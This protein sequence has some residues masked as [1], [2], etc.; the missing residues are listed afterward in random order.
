[1]ESMAIAGQ[2]SEQF[3]QSMQAL[4]SITMCSSPMEMAPT[5][6][7]LS[8]MPQH[9]QESLITQAIV[10]HLHTLCFEQCYSNIFCSEQP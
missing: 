2:T 9:M 8:Q 10:L 6:H 3:Q 7:S 5:G 1:M 4:A